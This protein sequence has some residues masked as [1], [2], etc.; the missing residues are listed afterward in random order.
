MRSSALFQHKRATRGNAQLKLSLLKELRILESLLDM[1]IVEIVA[2]GS[3]VD[4][5]TLEK[6][7]VQE[8]EIMILVEQL[9]RVVK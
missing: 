2:S 4:A 1:T 8:R 9:T 3:L 7:Q 6:R 5:K